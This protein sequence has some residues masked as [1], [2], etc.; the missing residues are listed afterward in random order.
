M[1]AAAIAI[2]KL[3]TQEIGKPVSQR[4][5]EEALEEDADAN[6]SQVPSDSAIAYLVRGVPMPAQVFRAFSSTLALLN[7]V[8][9]TPT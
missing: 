7:K 1:R 2:V 5:V 8:R 4:E 9:R 6:G 3:A